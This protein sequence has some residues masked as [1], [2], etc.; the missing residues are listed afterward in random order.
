MRTERKHKIE[1]LKASRDQSATDCFRTSQDAGPCSE[2]GQATHPMHL[3]PALEKLFCPSCCPACSARR[4]DGSVLEPPAIKN[5]FG[6]CPKCGRSDGYINHGRDHWF[7]CDR[8]GLKWSVG[9]NLFSDWRNETE[10]ERRRSAKLLARYRIAT[11]VNA[12]SECWAGGGIISSAERR[13][14]T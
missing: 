9:S 10:E 13:R 11:P 14:K 5:Y 1:S 3:V 8:H 2:C 7:V 4:K 12:P 6:G